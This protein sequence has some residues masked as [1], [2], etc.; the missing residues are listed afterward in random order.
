MNKKHFVT[1]TLYEVFLFCDALWHKKKSVGWVNLY[2]MKT[3]M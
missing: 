3:I 2:N 1:Y